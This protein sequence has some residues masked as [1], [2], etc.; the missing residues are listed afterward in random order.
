MGLRAVELQIAVPRTTEASKIQQ[1]NLLRPS[2]EQSILADRTS[3]ETE[4][5]RTRSDSVKESA[6]GLIHDGHPGEQHAP[7]QHHA[8]QPVE[9]QHVAP[10][11][12]PYKGKHIDLSF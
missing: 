3:E 6:S 8:E 7:R 9:E 5:M 12:H 2:I 11:E 4:R 10:A 1:E